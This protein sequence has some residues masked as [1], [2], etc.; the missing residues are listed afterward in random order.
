MLAVSYNGE[1]DE[2][3]RAGS[4]AW[5]WQSLQSPASRVT[6]CGWSVFACH[7]GAREAAASW[8]RLRRRLRGTRRC[9]GCGLRAAALAE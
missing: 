7:A 2:R 3:L 6:P 4:K 5:A 1:T 8:R 9:A